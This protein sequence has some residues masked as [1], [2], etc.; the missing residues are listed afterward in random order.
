EGS[1]K[2]VAVVG[3]LK[4]FPGKGVVGRIP[5]KSVEIGVAV[6]LEQTAVELICSRLCD[7]RDDSAGELAVLRRECVGL[8]AELFDCVGV[9]RRVSVVA[10]TGNVVAAIQIKCDGSVAGVERA[11]DL[12][13]LGR[14]SNGHGG[15]AGGVRGGAVVIGH[16]ARREGKFGVYIAV[17]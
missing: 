15:G 14:Q 7:N 17:D 6:E 1:A 3:G 5:T 13:I 9:G 12:D 4:R 2:V 16:H 8:D 10:H 11:V